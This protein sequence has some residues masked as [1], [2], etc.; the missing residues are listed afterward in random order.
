V[1]DVYYRDLWGTRKREDLLASLDVPEIEQLYTVTHPTGENRF[2]LRPTSVGA[3]YAVWPTVTDLADTEQTPGLQEMRREALIDP[4]RDALIE[5]MRRYFDAEVP[6]STLQDENCGPVLDMAEFDSMRARTAILRTE[7]FGERNV[8]RYYQRP[9]EHVWCYFTATRPIW[10]R[11]RPELEALLGDKNPAIVTRP[12]RERPEEGPHILFAQALPDYHLLRPNCS[13][14]TVFQANGR[15]NLSEP[16]R[17]WLTTIGLPDADSDRT[18]ALL[19]WYHALAIGY[20]PAWLAENA[21][22]IRQ[23]WPR[24]P[25][26]DNADQ[27]HTSAALGA[28]VA[29]LL[30]PDTPVPGVTA[31]TIEPALAA[32]AVPTRRG[33]RTMAEADR[34]MTAGWGH[35][36]KDGAV[37]PGRGRI[38]TRDYAPNEAACQAQAPLLGVRTHDVFLN[39]DA[40]WRN[41]PETVWR[42]TIGGYQVIKK[43]LSYREQPLLGRAL[44]PAEVRY[45]RDMARRLA[46]R[47]SIPTT[48]L[49][50]PPIGRCHRIPL[51]HLPG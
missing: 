2:A 36:G 20:A 34:T 32:L 21:D 41:I 18:V 40:C 33:G 49:A 45:V 16:V 4:D 10:N 1:T 19:P 7:S 42:F 48:T 43:W 51:P 9:F 24:V 13:A 8:R 44:T 35:A 30:D 27:L 12:Y 5:R 47:N 23:D 38:E 37:M 14:I 17:G 26:P 15:A 46:V 29:A 11:P 25:L 31:G 6:F 28:R 22:G 3:E 50:L 39:N